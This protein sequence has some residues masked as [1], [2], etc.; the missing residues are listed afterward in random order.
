MN[1]HK[2]TYFHV[3][4]QLDWQ[5]DNTYFIG[6]EY[7]NRYKELLSRGFSIPKL[8]GEQVPMNVILDGMTKFL[9]TNDRAA[10]MPENYHFNPSDTLMEVLPLIRSQMILIRELIFEET[11]KEYFSEKLSRYKGIHVIPSSIDSLAF[12]LPQ[13]KTPNAKIYK[14]ELTGKIH[15]AAYELLNVSS[16]PP[17]YIKFNAYQYWLGN[18]NNKVDSDEC[19]FEGL[20]KVVEIID[21]NLVSS[22]G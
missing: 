1:I 6:K 15:R 11:R 10:F 17:D 13:L 3:S 9:S 8:N 12:W 16:M 22:N 5:K 4:H 18:E 21:A 7:S 2:Q 19:L 20:V 14:I